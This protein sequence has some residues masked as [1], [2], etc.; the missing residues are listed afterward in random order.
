AAFARSARHPALFCVVVAVSGCALIGGGDGGGGDRPREG[1]RDRS[2]GRT[3]P[4]ANAADPVPGV[5]V[6]APKLPLEQ[7]VARRLTGPS[8]PSLASATVTPGTP[9]AA[10]NPPRAGERAGNGSKRGKPTATGGAGAG[11][12]AGAGIGIVDA[13]DIYEI[14]LELPR[15]RPGTDLFGEIRTVGSSTL[16]TL[17]NR[18]SEDFERIQS[19]I[20]LRITGGGSSAA[21]RPLVAGE[22]DLAPMAREMTAREVESFK[23]RWGYEP[24]RLTVALDAIA[25]FVH[26][27]NPLKTLTVAQLEAVFGIDP[28]RG[29]SIPQTWGELGVTGPLASQRINR[30][31]PRRNQGIYS[32]FRVL[33]LDGSDY[34][35][36][37]QSEPVSSAVVQAA[38][39]DENG[40]AFSSRLFA[41]R[42]THPVAIAAQRGER[43]YLPTARNITDGRYPLARRLYV[44]VNKSPKEAL[45]MPVAEFLRYV[46]S[47]EGQETLAQHGGIAM[48]RE[49]SDAEC[50]SKL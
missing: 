20:Q 11:A 37:M 16:T 28:K 1:F 15:Y 35:L 21:V 47:Y 12:G 18:W 4:R 19:R 48:S 44:Y 39:A 8:D 22:S 7:R 36:A 41:T 43:S 24:T 38:G 32:V 27:D 9:V 2:A 33:V 30:Y 17:F 31:G 49:I 23:A 46:C 29:L 50:S 10:A 26:K 45:P 40:I 25:V 14:D 42:R 13:D 6:P 5:L 34:T 3:T